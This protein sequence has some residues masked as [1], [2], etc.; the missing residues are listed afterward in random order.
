MNYEAGDT[1]DLYLMDYYNMQVAENA[2]FVLNSATL[3]LAGTALLLATAALFWV[4]NTLALS[5]S[6]VLT[7]CFA[8]SLNN[9][10]TSPYILFISTKPKWGFRV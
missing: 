7:P 5:M 10:L 8:K 9:F 2:G 1:M 6:L 4:G 3:L